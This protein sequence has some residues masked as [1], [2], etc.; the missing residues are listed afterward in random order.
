MNFPFNNCNKIHLVEEKFLTVWPVTF[1]SANEDFLFAGFTLNNALHQ[2]LVARYSDPNLTIDFDNFVGCLIR[3]EAMF[4]ESH[5]LSLI[6]ARVCD[7]N[8][9][10]VFLGWKINTEKQIFFLSFLYFYDIK[11]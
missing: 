7:R 8:A 10:N 6:Q 9:R 5:P 3:L 4:S 2:V 11:I 1:G